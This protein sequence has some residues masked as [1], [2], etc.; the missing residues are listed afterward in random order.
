MQGGYIIAYTIVY[1]RTYEY[2]YEYIRTYIDSN[3]KSKLRAPHSSRAE[4]R[5]NANGWAE[6]DEQKTRHS[7]LQTADCRLKIGTRLGRGLPSSRRS[8]EKKQIVDE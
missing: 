6:R 7:T 2:I 4:R 5:A 1:V 3:L 8:R